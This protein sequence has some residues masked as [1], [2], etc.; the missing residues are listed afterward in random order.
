[1]NHPNSNSKMDEDV[2][3]LERDQ[4]QQPEQ[5]AGTQPP[6]YNLITTAN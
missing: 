5:R 4:Q 3:I 6:D 1:M 2:F